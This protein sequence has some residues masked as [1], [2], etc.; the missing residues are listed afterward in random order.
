MLVDWAVRRLYLLVLQ[1]PL[2][3]GLG[4]LAL[5]L[6]SNTEESVLRWNQ[7]V[8]KIADRSGRPLAMIW[9]VQRWNSSGLGIRLSLV[10]DPKQA[11]VVARARRRDH[12]ALGCES[13]QVVGCASIGRRSW[14]PWGTPTLQL[15]RPNPRE[16][17]QGQY[18]DIAAHELGHLLGLRHSRSG[19][20]LMNSY[21]ECRNPQSRRIT[22]AGCPV[23]GKSIDGLDRQAWCPQRW[24]SR[25]LC[26][27][28]RSEVGQLIKLYGGRLNPDYSPWCYS[29]F[30]VKW[31]AW[32]VYPEW[33]PPG[34]KRPSWMVRRDGRWQ[35]G[36]RAPQRA[37]DYLD[38]ALLLV[39]N[40]AVSPRRAGSMIPSL[41]RSLERLQLLGAMRSMGSLLDQRL[42]RGY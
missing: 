37:R 12:F 13:H 14:P 6:D 1:L 11:D 3:A 30:G 23:K 4:F 24:I 22:P 38:L 41:Q 5:I 20:A 29:R 31:E 42:T 27:P 8:I 16:R 35:C 21:S 34:Q 17:D 40:E 36:P 7:P 33:V 18:A 25:S 10:A 2:L 39:E 9:A 32:C 28:T 26:G 15:L 19:C